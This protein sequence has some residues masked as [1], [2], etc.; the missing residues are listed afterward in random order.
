MMRKKD[1]ANHLKDVRGLCKTILSRKFTGLNL[2][3]GKVSS[4]RKISVKD[5]LQF[6]MSEMSKVVLHSCSAHARDVGVLKIFNLPKIQRS[7]LSVS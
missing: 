2:G 1:A 5:L 3:P 4:A 7:F 6:F